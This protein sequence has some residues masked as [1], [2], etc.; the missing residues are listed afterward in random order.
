MAKRRRVQHFENEQILENVRHA[1]KGPG[2][3]EVAVPRDR[4]SVV[5]PPNMEGEAEGSSYCF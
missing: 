5:R 1:A 4:A 2:L 3:V